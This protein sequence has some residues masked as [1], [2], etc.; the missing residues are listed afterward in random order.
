VSAWFAANG[1]NNIYA[2]LPDR[3]CDSVREPDHSSSAIFNVHDAIPPGI[4]KMVGGL[5]GLHQ[6]E[7]MSQRVVRRHLPRSVEFTDGERPRSDCGD[8]SDCR[9]RSD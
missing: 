9:G 3:V 2:Q 7:A 8:G 1:A 5:V 6:D 4:M